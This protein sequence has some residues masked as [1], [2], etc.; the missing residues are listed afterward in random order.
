M[1]ILKYYFLLISLVV[2]FPFPSLSAGAPPQSRKELIVR[3]EDAINCR[4]PQKLADLYY[5]E[6][7]EPGIQELHMEM[8]KTLVDTQVEKI[9]FYPITDDYQTE[10][11]EDGVQYTVNMP[12]KG[13]VQIQIYDDV[14]EH[15]GTITIPYGQRGRA[16]YLA[17]IKRNTKAEEQ[18]K[19]SFYT[20]TVQ[21]LLFPEPVSFKGIFVY[22]KD[23]QREKKKFF[24]EGYYKE[25]IEADKL[26]ACIVKKTTEDG[27]VKLT[28]RI[29]GDPVYSGKETGTEKAIVYKRK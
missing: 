10:I 18:S 23:G 8:F 16:L 24:A 5:W 1:N 25:I 3:I 22:E 12:V 17:G 27:W 9:N 6:G 21:G 7:V 20:I 14:V 19:Y 11:V 26:I 28:I 15:P 2:I 4:D 29:N 13:L